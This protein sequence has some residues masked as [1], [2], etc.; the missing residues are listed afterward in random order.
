MTTARR[1]LFVVPPFASHVFPTVAIGDALAAR[2]HAAAWVTYAQMASALP[3]GAKLYALS[4]QVSEAQIQAL[5]DAAGA[6]FLAGMK[7]FFEKMVFP[8]CADMLPGVEAAIDD[9]RPD[10]LVVDQMAFAG[11]LAAR[12]RNLRWATSATTAVILRDSFAQFPK[13]EAWLADH[14]AR[15]QREAGL[16]PVRWLDRSPAL[17]L[18]YLTRLL[19]GAD[20]VYPPQYQFVGPV[21]AARRDRDD[22]PWQ[23]LRDLPRVYV[24]L[25]MA[26]VE[27]GEQFFRIVAEALADLPLQ[28]IVSAPARFF[29]VV[30]ANFIVRPWVPAVRLY[31][32]L[33]AVVTHAGTT[34][35]EAFAHGLPAVV[36]PIAHDQSIFAEMAV[37]AGAAVRVSF[38][39]LTARELRAAVTTVLEDPSY[40]AAARRV[41]ASFRE[42]GGE[43]AA[44]SAIEAMCAAPL[45]VER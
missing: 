12:R 4:A 32:K 44:A 20:Q 3:P 41:Q 14:H 8:L 22:F 23:E 37:R 11:A 26:W 13:V 5:V 10:A 35:N 30:P 39:R 18:F 2:G 27:R 7:A 1:I 29:P 34:V 43:Q 31:P 17:V 9:F 28:V 40:R 24:S 19:C 38:P 15:I 21:L 25:G 45:A 42:A 6:S 33:D 16:A 36:A